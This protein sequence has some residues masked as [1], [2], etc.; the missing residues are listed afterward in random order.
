M[1]RLLLAGSRVLVAINFIH[2]LEVLNLK[3]AYP[4]EKKTGVRPVLKVKPG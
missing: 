4:A 3:L 2:D 1:S